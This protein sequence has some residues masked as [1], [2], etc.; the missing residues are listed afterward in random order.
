MR[1]DETISL[2]ANKS[3]VRELDEQ[4]ERLFELKTSHEN[5]SEK[6]GD[7]HGRVEATYHRIYEYVD[8][9]QQ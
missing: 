8:E 6:V 3:R 7:I 2:K 1:F 5:L 4:I 9:T